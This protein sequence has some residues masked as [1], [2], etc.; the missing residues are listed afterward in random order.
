MFTLIYTPVFTLR[1]AA[2]SSEMLTLLH[3]GFRPPGGGDGHLHVAYRPTAIHLEAQ[4]FHLH[5][6]KPYSSEISIWHEG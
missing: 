2:S 3:L 6:R 5:L 1:N 4:A